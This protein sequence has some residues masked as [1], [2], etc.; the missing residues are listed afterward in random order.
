MFIFL[1]DSNPS[2]SQ[3]H[4]QGVYFAKETS[5]ASRFCKDDDNKKAEVS[6]KDLQMY[7]VKVLVG[8][9]TIGTREMKTPPL[10]NDPANPGLPFDSLVNNLSNPTIFVIFNDNQCYPEYLI[11]FT[12]ARLSTVV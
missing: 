6:S 4:G 8:E 11:T 12:I 2:T 9:F 7:V 1:T 5:Y 10:K 3:K